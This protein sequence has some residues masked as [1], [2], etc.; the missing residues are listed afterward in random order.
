MSSRRS[1]F[2]AGQQLPVQAPNIERVAYDELLPTS[3]NG[4]VFGSMHRTVA[5]FFASH[6]VVH[7]RRDRSAAQSSRSRSQSRGRSLSR[8]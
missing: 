2:Q 8:D 1:G 5:E 4:T 7:E 3:W 6:D